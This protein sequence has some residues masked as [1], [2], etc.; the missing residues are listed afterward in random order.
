M[1]Q[2]KTLSPEKIN[3]QYEPI[4][5]G[6]SEIDILIE[7]INIGL[8]LR[9]NFQDIKNS[10]S[11]NLFFGKPEDEN[12]IDLYEES[13]KSEFQY[14]GWHIRVVR[15]PRQPTI[16]VLKTSQFDINDTGSGGL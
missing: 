3:P 15:L 8:C 12:L 11:V 13:I 16:I 6:T 4:Y 2:A 5:A 9:N 1:N 14:V 10:K 7:K